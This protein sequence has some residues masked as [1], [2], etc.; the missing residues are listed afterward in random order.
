MQR[1]LS[2]L[3]FLAVGF[4]WALPVAGQGVPVDEGVF[5]IV[6]DGSEVGTESFSIRRTG[7]GDDAQVIA[8]AEIRMD[9]PEGRL[10]L[11]PALQVSGEDMA[12]SAYQIKVSGHE[13]EEV[14]VHLDDRRFV[15]RV[16]S[17]RG[18]QER[19]Y[20]AAPG[21]LLLDTRAAHQYYFVGQRAGTTGGSV[22]IIVPRENR[23][24]DL[25][26]TVGGTESTTVG[27]EQVQARRLR[28]EGGGA[29]RDLW[30]D[31]EGRVLRLEF[32]DESYVVIRER[33]P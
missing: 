8:T 32:R 10:D 28:L 21:T 7:S 25:Q 13:Q 31:T 3:S 24:Y 27:G 14:Y 19:E 29:T 33:L 15:A 9:V 23:Q 5:L 20:R 17:E 22:P 26:V 16:R 18:Q 4:I 6:V 30:I 1:I 2:L 11:R 12:V